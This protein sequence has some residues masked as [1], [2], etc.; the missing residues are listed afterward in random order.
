MHDEWTDKL[1]EYLDGELPA[2]EQRA[3][4]AH[5]RGCAACALVLADLKRVVA[6]AQQ[7]G[8]VPRPPNADLWGGIAARI[9]AERSA[10]GARG[11]QAVAER[12]GEVVP[13]TSKPARRIAFTLPQLAAAAALVAA[14]SG[15]VVWSVVE[16]TAVRSSDQVATA[17]PPVAAPAVETPAQTADSGDRIAPVSMADAQYDAAV[18]DL[19]KALKQG[20]GRLDA[21]TIAIVEHNLQ[22]IDQAIDQARE[23]LASD[24]AN[25]YLSGHLVEARRRKLDLL[26]RAA[27]LTSETD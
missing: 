19:E 13:F 17:V 15:G 22:I 18:S 26:R 5:L 2:D 24:P 12:S 21:A 6:R 11:A 20:R 7:A 10:A 25:T 4:E 16:R 1:S 14:V 27:A 9:D 8:A 23:A 3:V